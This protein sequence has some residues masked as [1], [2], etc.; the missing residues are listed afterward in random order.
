MWQ[1]NH[2]PNS[3]DRETA[4]RGFAHSHGRGVFVTAAAAEFIVHSP[5]ARAA[6]FGDEGFSW[7]GWI[8]LLAPL[9]LVFDALLA[10][11]G[12]LIFAGLSAYDMHQLRRCYDEGGDD[13]RAAILGAL[14]LYLDLLNLLLSLL[15][16]TS[17]RR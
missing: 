16:L 2:L 5:Q 11:A 15:R 1:T 9:G 3:T 7:Q 13:D 14:T 12:V 4:G 10:V 8:I 6:L 17:R